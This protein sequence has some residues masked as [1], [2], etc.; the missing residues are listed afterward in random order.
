VTH[1]GRM[2]L[3]GVAVALGLA[4]GLWGALAQNP[5]DAWGG[6]DGLAASVNGAVITT[7]DLTLAIEAVAADKRN[8]LTQ[9]DRDRILARL[10][11]EE[12]LIQRGVEVGLVDSDTVVRKAIVNAMV[13]SVVG[14]AASEPPTPAQLRALYDESPALFSGAGRYHVTQIFIRDGPNSHERVAQVAAALAAGQEFADV[15]AR[16][17]DTGT[18]AIPAG[19]LPLAKLRE[20]VGPN[21]AEAVR[22]LEV[23]AVSGAVRVPGGVSFL[24]VIDARHPPPRAFAEVA[25]LVAAEYARRRDDAALRTYLDGLWTRAEITFA[26]GYTAHP[27]G[28][29]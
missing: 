15:Q 19:L 9:A 25:P 26:P 7:D 20:Y 1:S 3:A 23:G 4:L 21:A 17:A 16:Y 2:R 22:T 18:L 13:G 11:D 24:Q 14:D 28:L 8:P 29:P 12:L 6:S 5:F 27:D 10:I